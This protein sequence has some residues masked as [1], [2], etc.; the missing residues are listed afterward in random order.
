MFEVRML[1]I[2]RSTQLPLT[3]TPWPTRG[4]R[5]ASVNSF[6]FGGTNAHVVLD[7]AFH[8]LRFRGLE[9]NHATAEFPPSLLEQNNEIQQERE[10][11]GL[12][13]GISK[14]ANLEPPS[15]LLVLSSSSRTGIKEVIASYSSYFEGLSPSPNFFGSY[16]GDLAHT[17]NTRRSALPYKSFWV[18]SSLDDLQNVKEKTSSI[19]QPLEK[20]VLGFVFTGQGSQWAGMGR[21]LFKYPLFRNTIYECEDVLRS[22]GCRWSLQGWWFLPWWLVTLC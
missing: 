22:F 14:Y 8:Y 5:R 18:A 3:P 17:L 15:N 11:R 6:G 19:Y 1:L 20:P 9:G 4:L 16:L 12:P 10:E 2:R 7:D 21:E 13:N